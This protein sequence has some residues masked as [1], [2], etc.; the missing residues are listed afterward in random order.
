MI[1]TC[2]LYVISDEF[3]ERYDSSHKLMLNKGEKR[4]YYCGIVA[5]N[6]ILWLIPLSSQVDKYRKSIEADELKHGKGNCIF[7]YIAKVK[8]KDNAFLIGNAFPC[9]EA[10]IKKPFTI[11]GVPYVIQNQKDIAAVQQKLSRFIALVRNGRLHPNANIMDIEK[12][13]LKNL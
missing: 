6:G 4:P 10:F 11:A 3:F 8:G 2:G 13:L 9:T 12:S 7:H 1:K 5:G